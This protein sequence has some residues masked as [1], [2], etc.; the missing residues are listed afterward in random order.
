MTDSFPKFE[1]LIS[2]PAKKNFIPETITGPGNFYYTNNN[3][4]LKS[5]SQRYQTK[6]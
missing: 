1:F 3:D 2:F 6:I 4:E 5:F